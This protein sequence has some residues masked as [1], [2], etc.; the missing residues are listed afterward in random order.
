M[1]SW[2]SPYRDPPHPNI[3]QHVQLD[4]TMFKHVHLD[5][6]IQRA[7][8]QDMFKHVQLDLTTQ[9]APTPGNVQ[10]CLV[11]PHH[12]VS[13]HPGNVQTCPVG[14]HHTVSPPP[15]DMFKHVQLDLTTQWAPTPG[16]VQ[17]CPVGPHHT[18]S[19]HPWK[20]SNMSSW[21]SPHSEPL[22]LEMF[23]HVQLNLTT[24]WAPTPGNVQTCPV[25]PHHTVSPNPWKCSNMSS[26]TSPHSD[27][28]PLEMFKHV[29]L[30]LTTQW[31][32]TPG[33]VQTCPVGPHHTVSPH[34]WKCSNM[35]SWTSPHSE[36]PPLE[37][38]KHV[39][40]N[41]FSPHSEPPPL[42]MFKHVQLNLSTQW[43]PT[44]GNVQT[45]PVEPHHTV[46]PHHTVNPH[47]WKCSNMSSWTSPHSEPPPLEMFKH[48]QLNLTTQ[49]APTPG[50]VQTCPVGPHHTVSPHPWK[51]SN[52]S[53]W[54]SPH[55]E[56]PPLEMFKHVQLNLTTQWAP[57]PGNVQT[58]SVGP[59][60]TGTP[61]L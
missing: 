37:M 20:C 47:P 45:C 33:N 53:S 15:L 46:S 30:N 10:T 11:G 31:A 18:V 56:P 35:S 25:G 44:P 29:Q 21:T 12:T 51:C 13:P 3:L 1:F 57:T 50:N 6:S 14:P 4:F 23:K 49:W 17:T 59:H 58:C 39:Q 55:S 24:Q 40:L 52:M 32:P 54:T 41:M 48:V 27:P 7:L 5:L 9:L 16:N 26:W 36:P 42:E 43:A 34:P 61:H 38:F 8:P 22:P 2:T 60:H 19:P 28:P